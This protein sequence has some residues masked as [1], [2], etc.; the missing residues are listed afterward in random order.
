MDP[1]RK[2]SDRAGQGHEE[3]RTNMMP[4][5]QKSSDQFSSRLDDTDRLFCKLFADDV[6]MHVCTLRMRELNG[7]GEFTCI[8]CNRTA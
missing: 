5:E 8:G 2:K 4:W 1:A 7:R 3:K 6:P